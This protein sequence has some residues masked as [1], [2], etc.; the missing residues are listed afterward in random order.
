MTI[1]TDRILQIIVAM[2]IA[3][4]FIVLSICLIRQ[5]FYGPANPMPTTVIMMADGQTAVQDMLPENPK[6]AHV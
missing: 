5:T 6:N 1:N 4:L 3:L 2:A